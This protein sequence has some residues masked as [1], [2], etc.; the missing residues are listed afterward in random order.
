MRRQEVVRRRAAREAAKA[1]V[2][3]EH[4][5]EEAFDRLAAEQALE[6]PAEPGTLSPG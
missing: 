1:E 6:P 4:L 3:I 2:F 5:L